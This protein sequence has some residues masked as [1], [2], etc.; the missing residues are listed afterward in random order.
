MLNLFAAIL[1]AALMGFCAGMLIYTRYRTKMV[2]VS[3][4]IAIIVNAL[5]VALNVYALLI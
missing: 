2:W 3:A 4:L 1:C 5:S